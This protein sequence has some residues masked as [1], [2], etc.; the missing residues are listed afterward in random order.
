[1]FE[2]IITIF[3][4]LLTWLGWI[5]LHS[6]D[7]CTGEMYNFTYGSTIYSAISVTLFLCLVVFYLVPS[8][9]LCVVCGIVCWSLMFV[10]F[11]LVWFIWGLVILNRGDCKNTRYFTYTMVT[12]VLNFL[13][14]AYMSCIG[15]IVSNFLKLAFT[16]CVGISRRIEISNNNINA[17]V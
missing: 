9:S 10:I 12:V 6:S 17:L 14:L 2:S 3:P 5:T 13:E 11:N 15:T 4:A 1:M 7:I 16:S 8:A